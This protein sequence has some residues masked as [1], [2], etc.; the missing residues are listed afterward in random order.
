MQQVER[1]FLIVETELTKNPA[2]DLRATADAATA[3]A[4]LLQHGYGA[5]EDKRVPGFARLA[6][7]TESWMLQIALEARQAHGDLT[8]ELFRGGK[9][10]YCAK[11]HAAA[12]VE[13]W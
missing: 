2:G 12:K 13:P 1:Q 4:A 11:C 10:R 8:R 6:R 9:Q 5:F 3:V 7:D